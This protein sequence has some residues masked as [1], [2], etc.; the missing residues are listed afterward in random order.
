M[1]VEKKSPA[2]SFVKYLPQYRASLQ[3]GHIR[4][5]YRGLMDYFDHLKLFLAKKHPDYFVSVVHYG[6]M[7]YTYFYFFPK[8][9]KKQGLKIVV[10]FVHDGFR[11]EVWLA[12]YNKA[13]QAKY[14]RLIKEAGWNRY[15]LSPCDGGDSI[16]EHVLVDDADFADSDAL[17]RQIE[18]GALQFIEDVVAFLSKQ[19]IV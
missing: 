4:E 16:L 3:E 11:F 5:A 19:N 8:P 6:K 9:L 1:T 2:T 7:D 13:I 10:L 18:T 14:R 17:T 12:G 15:S